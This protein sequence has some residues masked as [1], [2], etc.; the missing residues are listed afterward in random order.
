MVTGSHSKKARVTSHMCGLQS[1]WWPSVGYMGEEEDW[2]GWT[3][4]LGGCGNSSVALM[5]S[6]VIY[7][8]LEKLDFFFR[9]K[10]L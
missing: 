1:H 10:E 5:M 6:D 2:G 3:D 7:M 8:Y 4:Q 9:I